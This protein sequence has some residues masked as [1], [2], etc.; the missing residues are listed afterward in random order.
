M[1]LAGNDSQNTFLVEHYRPGIG[2]EA[3][4]EAAQRMCGVAEEM[5]TAA[6]P[7]RFLHSTL[8]PEDETAF[9]VFR[10]PSQ[11]IV[12]EA[13]QRAGVPFDRIVSAL[14]LGQPAGD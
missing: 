12:E 8:V 6:S 9:C 2:V 1:G 4:S 10:A 5:D 11:A 14:E 13:Y 3:F 7:I